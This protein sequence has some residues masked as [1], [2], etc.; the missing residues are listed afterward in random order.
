METRETWGSLSHGAVG[1]I[2]PMAHCPPWP[3]RS[4]ASCLCG[5]QATFS[6][7][8]QVRSDLG[9]RSSD[10][11]PQG[12]STAAGGPGP[13][14][15]L[16]AHPRASAPSTQPRGGACGGKGVC[17]VG[18]PPGAGPFGLNACRGPP[19]CGALTG[20]A[21]SG[22]SERELQLG[23]PGKRPHAE[24]RGPGFSHA[25]SAGLTKAGRLSRSRLSSCLGSTLSPAGVPR[26]RE[27]RGG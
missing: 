25:A 14:Q 21:G 2:A 9:L 24:Q 5:L 3:L 11:S 22:A 17:S 16:S 4:T 8:R 13:R 7:A 10:P 20:Q 26:G 18:A 19:G 15:R 6:A 1:P 23:G 27:A 12:G